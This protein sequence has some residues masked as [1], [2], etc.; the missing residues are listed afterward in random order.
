M[1]MRKKFGG[2]LAAVALIGMVL[3]FTGLAD[4]QAKEVVIGRC[5]R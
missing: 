4:V 5:I 1:R 2:F 3:G